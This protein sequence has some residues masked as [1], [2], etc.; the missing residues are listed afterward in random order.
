MGKILESSLPSPGRR[1]NRV[2]S[3]PA[4]GMLCQLDCGDP[5]E[6]SVRTKAKCEIGGRGGG[7]SGGN[8]GVPSDALSS[9]WISQAY[10][11]LP[12]D[13]STCETNVL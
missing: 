13:F 9:C 5:E 1:E 8:L 6:I 2:A 4:C 12:L 10:S 11:T 3:L 7:E